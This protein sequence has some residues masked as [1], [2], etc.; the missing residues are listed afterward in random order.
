MSARGCASAEDASGRRGHGQ[1]SAKDYEELAAVR[2]TVGV[3]VN[4]R[5]LKRQN[6]AR[7]QGKRVRSGD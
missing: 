5:L 4:E 1:G 7:H 2:K 3:S 6:H